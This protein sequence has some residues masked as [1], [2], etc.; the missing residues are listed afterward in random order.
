[1]DQVTFCCLHSGNLNRNVDARDE[2]SQGAER[3][4]GFCHYRLAMRPTKR[5]QGWVMCEI[6]LQRVDWSPWI[7]PLLETPHC[8]LKELTLFQNLHLH[9][10]DPPCLSSKYLCFLPFRRGSKSL[11]ILRCV[12]QA[13]MPETHYLCL[14][15]LSIKPK[16][17]S[18]SPGLNVRKIIKVLA[19]HW[20][21]HYFWLGFDFM[22]CI[23]KA[24]CFLWMAP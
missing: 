15:S 21:R 22:C 9:P 12:S 2:G 7:R 3:G 24:P 1:M 6:L 5:W 11:G 4:K 18:W 16:S 10:H 23:E 19:Y 20:F 13:C 8:V 17:T 14:Q